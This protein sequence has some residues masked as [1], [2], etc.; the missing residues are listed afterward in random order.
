[1]FRFFF[2][3]WLCLEAAAGLAQNRAVTGVF[4]DED[5]LPLEGVTVLLITLPDST[6][7]QM[8][9]TDSTGFFK[10]D[11]VARGQFALLN[12]YLGFVSENVEFTMSAG[13]EP[14][15]L[16]IIALKQAPFSLHEVQISEM[17]IPIIVRNDTIS[18]HAGSFKTRPNAAVL[19]LLKKLPGIEVSSEGT[20]RAQGKI[21]EN[22]LVDGHPF[23][24]SDQST[25]TRVLPADAI[26][27]V[28]VYDQTSKKADFTGVDDGIQEKTINLVLKEDRKKGW[29]GH[30]AAAGGSSVPG[31]TRYDGDFNASRFAP[32]HQW[33]VTSHLGNTSPVRGLGIG[34]SGFSQG[35]NLGL[36][37]NRVND[38]RKSVYANYQYNS[39]DMRGAEQVNRT[40]FLENGGFNTA[41]SSANASS[42]LS[43][44]GSF[45]VGF[46]RDT[47]WTGSVNGDAYYTRGSGSGRDTSRTQTLAGLPLNAGIR[48][49]S[50]AV[51]SKNGSLNM[52]YGRR[53]NA[54]GR[55]IFLNSGLSYGISSSDTELKSQNSFYNQQG[56][57]E[58]ADTV[59]QRNQQQDRNHYAAFSTNFVEPINS[60]VIMEA[61]WDY[62]L[63]GQQ[64]AVLVTDHRN[65]QEV[66]NDSLSNTIE[67]RIGTH[68]LGSTVQLNYKKWSLSSFLKVEFSH[69]LEKRQGLQALEK[70]R[71]YRNFNPGL[72]FNYRMTESKSFGL[73]YHSATTQP[74]IDD[75]NSI[76]DYSDPLNV[77]EGN[78]ALRPE[79]SH[80]ISLEYN[81]MH[82]VKYYS[83]SINTDVGYTQNNIVET[84]RIDSHFVRHRRAEN[85]AGSSRLGLGTSFNLPLKSW[86]SNFFIGVNAGFSQGKVLISEK[87]NTMTNLSFYPNGRW[88]YNPA[89]WFSAS[90]S[91]S[92]SKNRT[93]YNVAKSSAQNY[94]DT[95]FGVEFNVQL[96]HHF[97]I[98]SS[99]NLVATAG[100]AVG[101]N[102]TLPIWNAEL[103]RYFLKGEQLEIS[104]SATDILNK[105]I[106]LDNSVNLNYI[107]YRKA[108]ALSRFFLL[109]IGYL[110]RQI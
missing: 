89:E 39:S 98:S 85:V 10:L 108:A 101:Y 66:R 28:E 26:E 72:S 94:S 87:L 54:K 61:G 36:N 5:R 11:G 100:R 21:V 73:S 62:T 45:N 60:K 34:S 24:E 4:Q 46:E 105:N 63:D 74:D 38:K 41:E 48:E 110:I 31:N 17:A 103:S 6:P 102:R 93:L 47:T 75:L 95:N 78:P 80:S 16:G 99:L 71:N 42:S 43:H 65:G 57:L 25:T 33:S 53:L 9:T 84:I 1:M 81:S 12:T 52:D 44:S 30:A 109:K 59:R 50:S 35:S 20:I 106:G 82:P 88:E 23:F 13:K 19:E 68:Q 67:N 77:H 69:F 14:L 79:V 64:T 58:R 40:V 51:A 86:K 91:I 8:T 96:P 104:L 37:Y 107:E 83:F 27:K 92:F 56:I 22:I 55:I 70:T 7:V 90:T 49:N 3:L 29:F 97:R 18:Y 32:L 2:I 76:P 15:D